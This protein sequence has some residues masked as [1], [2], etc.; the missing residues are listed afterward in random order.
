[1]EKS[2]M[3]IAMTDIGVAKNAVIVGFGDVQCAFKA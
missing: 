2:E 3:R 1:L